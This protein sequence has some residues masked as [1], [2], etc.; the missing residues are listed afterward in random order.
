MKFLQV[1]IIFC[2]S[3]VLLSVARPIYAQSCDS[4]CSSTEECKQKITKCQ[5]AWDQMEAAKK[6]HVDALRKMEADI[7]AFLNRIKVI[8]GELVKKAAAIAEGGKELSSLLQIANRRIRSFYIRSSNVNLLASLLTSSDIGATL[9]NYGYQQAITNEDKRVITQTA[10]MVKDLEDKKKK[11]E[12]ERATLA[13]MKEDIDLRAV[14]VRK[15][16][17]DANAYQSKLSST[18]AS[19]TSQQKEFLGAK[20]SGLNLPTSLGAGPLICTDDRKL[21]PGFS[22][23]FAFFTFG[24]PHRVGMNQYGAL[25]RANDNQ[26]AETILKAYFQNVEIKG[27][28]EGESVVVNGTN[29]FGQTFSNRSMNIEDYLIHIYEMPTSWHHFALEAQAIAARSYAISEQRAKGY[30]YP[31]Q[32]DQVVKLEE[33]SQSWKDAVSTTKGKVVAQGGQPIKAWFSS[34]DGGYTYS[35]S[36]VWGGDRSWTK[37]LRDTNGDIGS[38]SDL[39]SKAYDKDSPCFYAAQGWRNEYGKSAWLKSD[40]VAD[41]TNVLLLVQKDSSLGCYVFQPDKPAPAPDPNKGCSV[42]DNWSVNR[43]KQELTSRGV[44][45]FSTVNN[46][47]VS[48]DFGTG[49]ASNISITGDAGAVNF[50]GND[51]KNYFNQRAPA[52]IQIV[53]PL[54]NV[55]RK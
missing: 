35:S 2:F 31:S 40:E 14:S 33:N 37:R 45:P 8:E 41:I 46:I 29:E 17:G 13:A 38:F 12:S 10:V 16:V 24:I 34:T 23:A 1:I 20:L 6:P 9:R 19:L 47:S 30:L 3:F 18:I 5:E 39:F 42:T 11:L 43:V 36:D 55:E 50:S 25:G 54:F 26:D 53:G 7:T 49:I 21:N 28:F 48:A 32:K 27:G 22:P 4:T 44:T 52:N 15:L 51:F